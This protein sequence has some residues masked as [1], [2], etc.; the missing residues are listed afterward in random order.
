MIALLHAFTKPVQVSS[1]VLSSIIKEINCITDAADAFI[2]IPIWFWL[3]IFVAA[4]N[5]GHNHF[6]FHASNSACLGSFGSQVLAGHFDFKQCNA[7][8]K[9]F[10][11]FVQLIGKLF[12]QQSRATLSI[13]L[14]AHLVGFFTC[15][16]WMHIHCECCAETLVLGLC[17]SGNVS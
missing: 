11:L 9:L 3:C 5:I 4:F 17:S 15:L 12:H 2:I 13:C 8:V 16:S 6:K 14:Q 10:K 7:F 1:A